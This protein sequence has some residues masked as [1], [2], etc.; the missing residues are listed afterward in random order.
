MLDVP[1]ASGWML[2]A[3]LNRQE[4]DL[5]LAA[6]LPPEVGPLKA[7]SFEL[8]TLLAGVQRRWQRGE[9]VPFVVV[10]IGVARA[11]SSA[12]ILTG[13]IQPGE[14]GRRLGTSEGLA[15]SLGTGA[16]LALDDRWGLRFEARAQLSDLPSELGGQL[17]QLEIGV[18]L[19]TRL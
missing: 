12:R 6:E 14:S 16:R 11:E 15:L 2:E 18:G 3:L 1:I 17:V 19:S 10:A 4:G 8:T 5:R 13:P 7:E 9:L